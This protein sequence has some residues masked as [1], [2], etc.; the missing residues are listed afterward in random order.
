MGKCIKKGGKQE[1]NTRQCMYESKIIIFYANL[2]LNL[3]KQCSVPQREANPS[4]ALK[5]IHSHSWLVVEWKPIYGWESL[6]IITQRY[7]TQ[8]DRMPL[9]VSHFR[10]SCATGQQ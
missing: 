3:K 9:S 5:Y 1:P 8:G 4:K 10:T 6:S 7:G 2:N